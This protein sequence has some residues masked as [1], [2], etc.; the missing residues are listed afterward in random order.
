MTKVVKHHVRGRDGK[1]LT[2]YELQLEL[3]KFKYVVLVDIGE[4]FQF[5]EDYLRG[6]DYMT[7]SSEN[8]AKVL[9]S[10]L[11]LY[12]RTHGDISA[13]RSLWRGI[14][15]VFNHQALFT[16]FDWSKERLSVSILL[17]SYWPCVRP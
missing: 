11:G 16:D 3:P 8:R 9:V 1:F 10:V 5:Y 7:S 17:A 15:V 12:L 13:L 14:G 6:N 2:P 4:K